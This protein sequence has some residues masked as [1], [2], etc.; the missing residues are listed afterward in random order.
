MKLKPGNLGPAE[1]HPINCPGWVRP[2]LW[3]VLQRNRLDAMLLFED[4]PELTFEIPT[5]NGWTTFILSAQL[6][7]V[8]GIG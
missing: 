1:A 8:W 5:E 3:S 2:E 6:P 7:R 4:P